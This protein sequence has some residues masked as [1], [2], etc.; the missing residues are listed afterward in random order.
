MPKTRDN[1]EAVA[2]FHAALLEMG[3]A[4]QVTLFSASDFGRNLPSNGAGTDHAWG[5]HHFVLGAGLPGGRLYGRFP[6]LTIDGPDDI[7]QGRWVPACSTEQLGS[8][9]AAWFG[10]DAATRAA[11]FPNGAY[12]PRLPGL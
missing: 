11:V 6:D 12:F 7:G 1:S 5:S 9:L 2:A 3:R 10:A 8:E 4:D